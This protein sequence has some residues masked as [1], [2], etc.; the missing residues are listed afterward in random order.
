MRTAVLATGLVLALSSVALGSPRLPAGWSWR[1]RC[2]D[3]TCKSRVLVDAQGKVVTGA[4]P[5]GIGADDIEKAYSIDTSLGSGVTVAVID[6]FGYEDIESDLAV[7]RS[8]H[9]LPPC[10]IASGCLTVVNEDGNPTP[11]PP[12]NADWIGETVLDVAMVSAACPMCN[13]VVVQADEDGVGLDYGQAAAVK[14]GVAAISNSWGGPEYDGSPTE[15]QTF[16]NP[17]IGTFVSSGDDGYDLDAGL[18][19]YPSTSQY[20]IAVG[21]TTMTADSS[22]RGYTEVAWNN[23]TGAGGSSCSQYIAKPS[24]QPAS[25]ACNM[26]AA[27]DVSAVADGGNQGIATYIAKQGGWNQVDGTSAASP[28]TAAMFAGAGHGDAGPAFVYKHP[29]AFLDITMGNNGTCQ[30]NLCIA[31]DGWDGPT[32]VGTP[33]QALIKAIGGGVGNGPAIAF[34]YPSDGDTVAP[35]FSIQ[36]APDV[37]AA[38]VEIDLDGTKLGAVNAMPFELTTSPLTVTNGAH[39][40]T[41]IAYDIDHNSNSTTIHVTEGATTTPGDD[42][43]SSGCAAGGGRSAGVGLL[44]ALGAVVRKRRS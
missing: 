21:G 33:N 12:E 22:T 28:A 11:L 38:W 42:D 30:S 36:V 14:Y 39:T 1:P 16:N 9:G 34:T 5:S 20:V 31:G 18:P 26:R 24:Y 6:A 43:S 3:H 10:T 32:G 35:G 19:D 8:T 7:Y 25:A 37:D 15:E 44:L 23:A 2:A 13:I 17:G 29:E 27:S 4:L 41:A 40:I